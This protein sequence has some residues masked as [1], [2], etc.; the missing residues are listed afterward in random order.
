MGSFVRVAAILCVMTVARPVDAQQ[1]DV[2]PAPARVDR[3]V[4]LGRLP[5]PTFP[6]DDRWRVRVVRQAPRDS[7]RDGALIGAALGAAYGVVVVSYLSG[8]SDSVGAAG[9]TRI[10]LG[11]AGIGLAAGALIDR[12]R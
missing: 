10:I 6:T 8:S 1:A 12:L 2:R 3:Q 5:A 4:F 7:I 11:S 9:N